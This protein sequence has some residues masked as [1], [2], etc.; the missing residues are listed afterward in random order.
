MV[1]LR[2]NR[3]FED[4]LQFPD[5]KG[6]VGLRHVGLLANR[7]PRTAASPRILDWV[8]CLVPVHEDEKHGPSDIHGG[9]GET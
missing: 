2:K 3:S 9:E 6:G 8:F 5:D 4:H 7:P 1:E